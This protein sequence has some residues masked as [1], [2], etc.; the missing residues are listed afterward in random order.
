MKHRVALSLVVAVAI[1]SFTSFAEARQQLSK[2]EV[3]KLF[4]GKPWRSPFGRF[5]FKRNGTYTYKYESGRRKGQTYGPVHYKIDDKGVITDLQEKFHYIFYKKR[6]GKYEYYWSGRRIYSNIY[7]GSQ[8][9]ASRSC[10]DVLKVCYSWCN[11]NN[12]KASCNSDCMA[13]F[14]GCKSSGY[15]SGWKRFGKLQRE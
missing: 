5:H 6:N 4:I 14:S 7:L 15:F 3:Q 10:S 9:T 13:R 1:L 12:Q 11:R 2:Q 8:S